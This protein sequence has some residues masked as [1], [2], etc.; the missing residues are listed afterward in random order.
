VD[1]IKKLEQFFI[2]QSAG[3]IIQYIIILFIVVFIIYSLIKSK[4]EF[5][6]FGLLHFKPNQDYEKSIHDKLDNIAKTQ[7]QQ[8]DDLGR[9]RKESLKT[10]ILLCNTSYERK[11]YLFDEYKKLGG[12][13]WLNDWME[14]YKKEYNIKN[15]VA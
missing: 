6:L 11:L 1:N 9:L 5:N 2:P 15:G 12:N 13:G 4:G 10:Q 7:E 8:N 3:D 14:N